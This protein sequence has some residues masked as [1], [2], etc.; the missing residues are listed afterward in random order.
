MVRKIGRL[1]E[2]D[3]SQS[4]VGREKE[5]KRNKQTRE[6]R[7][8]HDKLVQHEAAHLAATQ[9]RRPPNY[10][11]SAPPRLAYHPLRRT[12]H[13]SREQ[14]GGGRGACTRWS[15]SHFTLSFCR[16]SG[17]SCILCACGLASLF[18]RHRLAFWST[19]RYILL[20][21]FIGPAGHTLILT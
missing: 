16:N 4:T 8:T 19:Y 7:R 18:T 13:V 1:I 2:L 20:D 17:F 9:M 10:L 14:G 21:D 3:Y 15:V 6:R 11:P 5:T 12:Q